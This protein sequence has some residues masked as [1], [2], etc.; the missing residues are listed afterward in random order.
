MSHRCVFTSSVILVLLF[1]FPAHSQVSD[2]QR[3]MDENAAAATRKKAIDLLKSVASQVDSLRSVENRARIGSNLAGSLWKHDE[4]LARRILAAVEQEIKTGFSDTD[5]DQAAHFHRL[6]VFNYLRHNT[7]ERIAKHDPDLALDFLRAT[8]LPT[9]AVPHYR[10]VDRDKPLEMRLAGQIAA[11]N[12]QLALKLGR[13]SL[14]DGF[15]QDLLSLVAQLGAKDK[16][17]SLTLYREI[18]DK[19]KGA[20]LPQDRAATSIALG[21]VRSFRPP[22]ADELVYRDLIGMLVTSAL[23]S[24]CADAPAFELPQICHALGS[25]FSQVEKYYGPR[26][27][28][29]KRLADESQGS[30][31]SSSEVWPRVR[32][33]IDEGT[34]D[35]ILAL[36]EEY[37]SWQGQ[38][39]WGAMMKAQA[40]GDGMRAR[41]IAS[42]CPNEELRREMLARLDHDQM[43]NSVN[44]EKLTRLQQRLST[45]VHNEERVYLLVS[46]AKRIGSNDRKAA[47]EL[48]SQAGQILDS[49]KPGKT[50][51]EG[52]IHLAMA[53]CSLKSNRGFAIMESLI[54]KL[55][56]LVTA[57]ATLNGLENNYLSDGEWNMTGAGVL[58]GYLTVLAQNAGYFAELDFERSVTLANQFE[59]PEI[60]LMAQLK[61]AQAILGDQPK[62]ALEFSSH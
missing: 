47:L 30:A 8:R 44:P 54:P 34:V 40:L 26:T 37:P 32:G 45:M 52:Q 20:N 60:R 21:L 5:P 29:L 38:I 50:Q 48:L 14:A 19:L 3:V 62:T 12:P 59:R 31:D 22:F 61:I 43:W 17:A 57:A 25:V 2:P 18:V 6:R 58:G 13:E 49:A 36:R 27:A 10:M 28:A 35:E 56:E 53:Y 16:E 33:I 39:Y 9:D 23:A 41:Q 51:L 11:K 15:S 1:S 7:I 4:K 55:N 46:T 24:G 42:E